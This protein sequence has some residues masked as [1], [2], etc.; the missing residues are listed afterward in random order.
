MSTP[1]NQPLDPSWQFR[2]TLYSN[3]PEY[4]QKMKNMLN[5]HWNHARQLLD[6]NLESILGT[7]IRSRCAAYFQGAIRGPG[8]QG[9]FYPLPPSNLAK[10][11]NYTVVEIVDE[12]PSG[13]LTEQDVLNEIIN[14]HKMPP[15]KQKWKIYSSQAT[16]I[17]HLPDF[18]NLPPMLIRAHNIEKYSIGGKEEVLLI[19]LWLETP[20]G[21]AYV[22]VAVLS[23]SVKAQAFWKRHF[24]ASPAGRNV[25][26][27]KENGL[28]IRVHGNTMF[29]GWTV[30]ISLFPSQYV[31]PP[32]CMLIE[33]YGDIRTTAYTISG[34]AGAFTAKQNGFNA[35][36]TFMHSSSKYSGPGTD[37]FFVRDFIADIAP[38]TSKR[39]RPTLEHHLVEKRKM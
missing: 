32:A 36:V 28:Q 13:K 19:N 21:H 17:V 29:A 27:A 14:S 11:R 1:E 10:K 35:F 7:G 37:G 22:P 23:D 18:F 12:D 5:E 16:A 31:L 15:E 4:L 8:P 24:A 6:D 39:H 20:S 33:G 38:N 9:T 2:N 30:P 25:Q 34:P 26:L 3:D